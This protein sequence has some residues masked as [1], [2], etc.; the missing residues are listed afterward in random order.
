MY[1][2]VFEVS[3]HSWLI[4]PTVRRRCLAVPSTYSAKIW[5][6]IAP[7]PDPNIDAPEMFPESD[8][9]VSK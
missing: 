3:L 9:I 2:F 6:A 5:G 4:W 1:T 7:L 8:R